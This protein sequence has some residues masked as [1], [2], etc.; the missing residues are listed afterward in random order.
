MADVRETAEERKDSDS[1]TDTE[2]VP[3]LPC[4]HKSSKDDDASVLPECLSSDTHESPLNGAHPNAF[5]HDS[6]PD[7]PSMCESAPPGTL[8]NGPASHHSS[9]ELDISNKDG[10]VPN[11]P[12]RPVKEDTGP[13]VPQPSGELQSDSKKKAERPIQNITPLGKPSESDDSESELPHGILP[14]DKLE[15]MPISQLWMRKGKKSRSIWDFDSGS[16][17]SESSSEG[18]DD[19]N[20]VK[21][22]EF[23]TFLMNG[24]VEGGSVQKKMVDELPTAS[25]RKRRRKTHIARRMG[26]PEKLYNNLS[27][28]AL[29][30]DSS[31]FDLFVN[32]ELGFGKKPGLTACA[33]S[34]LENFSNE[35]AVIKELDFREQEEKQNDRGSDIGERN[36]YAGG[37]P[38]LI[39]TKST[40]CSKQEPSFFPCTKCNVKFNEKRH[41]HRHMMY[42]LDGNN[43]ARLENTPRPFICRE[44]GR[45]FRDRSSL[46]KHMVIHQARRE[47]LIEEIRGL[48]KLRDEGRGARLQCP[49]CSFGTNCP[50]TFIRHAKMHEKDKRYY[51]CEN[52]DHVAVTK[53]ELEAHQRVAHFHHS[54]P[55]PP[56]TSYSCTM[57]NFSTQNRNVL[58]K[59]I[60]LI[61]QQSYDDDCEFEPQNQESEPY[62]FEQDSSVHQTKNAESPPLPLQPELRAE[63][64]T[65]RKDADSSFC[66]NGI[67][68]HFERNRVTQKACEGF[69]SSLIKWSFS[70]SAKTRSKSFQRSDKS[71]K[72]SLQHTEKID[73]TTGLP[74]F[75]ED[76]G[77]SS[78]EKKTKYVSSSHVYPP[79]RTDIFGKGTSPRY[80]ANHFH[81]SPS[82]R[83]MSIP[84]RNTS[85]NVPY[86]LLPK[87]KPV[88]SDF[89][90]SS[91]REVDHNEDIY[92]FR[93]CSSETTLKF[94]DSRKNE[95]S[96]YTPSSVIHRQGIA[97]TGHTYPSSQYSDKLEE[98]SNEIQTLIVKEECIER[99]VSES[100]P[101][102][103]V[104]Q[105][106]PYVDFDI[107]PVFEIERKACPYCPAMFESGVG[108]SNHV[109]GHLHRLGLS[110]D[111][112]HVVSPEQVASQDRHPRIRRKLSSTFRRTKKTEKSEAQTEHT[113]PLCWGWFDTKTGLSNHVRGHLKRIGRP[114]L[115][116][117]K[118][119]LCI[120]NE[121]LH[122]E[123]ERQNILRELRG[124]QHLSRPFVSQKFAGS[125]GLFLTPI[126][127]PVKIQHATA[128]PG[129]GSR[130]DAERKKR[131]EEEVKDSC[132]PPS[133][134]L[135]ELL[136]RRKLD[137]EMELRDETLADRKQ[138]IGTGTQGLRPDPNWSQERSEINKKVC[139]HCNATF[140][141]A[142]SLSNHLRAYTRR[143]RIAML[144]GTTYD[145][146]Q[147][148]PR[149]RT[150]PKKKIF[151]TPLSAS[152][153]IYRLTCRF[154]DLVFQGPLSVQEDWV[155]HLQRHLMH[156]S[157]PQSGAAMVE[158]TAVCTELSPPPPERLLLQRHTPPQLPQGVT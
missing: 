50:K 68:D 37:K 156:T 120:L 36:T 53:L 16:E 15:N 86:R 88:S 152:E 73:V 27:H 93:E 18:L 39:K 44:C 55:R 126:G 110:Y 82:K 115:S 61:H 26:T 1:Q 3:E 117:S 127:V 114:I 70:S 97:S 43:Q 13:D 128:V 29:T 69:S 109:R 89:T 46:Q 7:A 146:K 20:W 122:D 101:D 59:H 66:A 133:S 71:S 129:T 79:T 76:N 31:D 84:Y 123:N 25:H 10:S 83:K 107:H 98:D 56:K 42:H 140:H 157:V 77:N 112:R 111:A 102:S 137:G 54:Q 124:K 147:R 67:A 65:L 63:M 103:W 72:L 158:V 105:K 143:Q 64:H 49:Q 33:D 92:D 142:V 75:E 24:R 62:M 81:R 90:S 118:S 99:E 34:C 21:R 78:L 130:G 19:L 139:I 119:P 131:L 151:H 2:P 11:E 148:K 17:S 23:M 41:L 135:V 6:I 104:H 138:N 100:T 60:E 12:P 150:G 32:K 45:S 4:P 134:T 22:E 38:E 106:D 116:T 30:E 74:Y 136:K 48:N 9:E 113:C 154:C 132:E 51:C 144:E 5:V 80:V 121:L 153:E 125:D 149:S 108:L 35:T 8:V 141:S 57:C 28:G 85:E 40:S 95:Q 96:S 91:H 94:Q 58:K 87:C 14:E 145:C 155:K 47:R 52:C